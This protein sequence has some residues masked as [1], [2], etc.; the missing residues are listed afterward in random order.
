MNSHSD[1]L[2]AFHQQCFSKYITLWSDEA[3]RMQIGLAPEE[4]AYL[5]IAHAGAL[6]RY[7]G[8][9]VYLE[10]V[11]DP[12]GIR[13]LIVEGS[14]FALR[15]DLEAKAR[16]HL[17]DEEDE[18]LVALVMERDFQ[19]CFLSVAS[20]LAKPVIDAGDSELLAILAEVG[21]RAIRFDRV[22]DEENEEVGI[23]LSRHFSSELSSLPYPPPPSRAW[24]YHKALENAAGRTQVLYFPAFQ[25]VEEGILAVAASSEPGAKTEIS[26]EKGLVL[27][28]VRRSDGNQSATLSAP[29]GVL[30]PEV[31]ALAWE[32]GNA[33]HHVM[34]EPFGTEG[35]IFR[36][37]LDSTF[38]PDRVFRI[39]QPVSLEIP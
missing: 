32:V 35:T 34:L 6:E 22:F 20:R 19:E 9:P 2:T 11:I 29:A 28:L 12:P 15:F 30:K 14:A 24:W 5:T 33:E 25:P 38:N 21:F 39:V 31:C 13:K 18:E 27:K 4:C 10:D 1:D 3:R 17:T 16:I 7:R 37:L 26:L 23:R 8:E 36:G